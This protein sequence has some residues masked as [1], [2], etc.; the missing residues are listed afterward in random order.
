MPD[1]HCALPTLVHLASDGR[2][3]VDRRSEL[4]SIRWADWRTRYDRTVWAFPVLE[5]HTATDRWMREPKP[6]AP[7][8]PVAIA[9]RTDDPV[10]RAPSATESATLGS[11][12]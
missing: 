6:K 2:I 10:V 9:C 11:R 5:S 3:E 7:L 8:T 1:M 12:A 4:G